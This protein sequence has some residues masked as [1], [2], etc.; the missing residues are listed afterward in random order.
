MIISSLFP[1]EL[2]SQQIQTKEEWLGQIERPP[3]TCR[4]VLN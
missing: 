4:Y 2:T 1:S 3:K